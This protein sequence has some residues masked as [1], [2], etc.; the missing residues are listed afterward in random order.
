M[1]KND[2]DM[3]S[4]SNFSRQRV[5]HDYLRWVQRQCR[6]FHTLWHLK[7]R[8]RRLKSRRYR[9]RVRRCETVSRS[10][11]IEATLGCVI[12]KQKGLIEAPLRWSYC[13]QIPQKPLSGGYRERRCWKRWH[14]ILFELRLF[15]L[16]S[17]WNC[18][19]R[20]LFPSQSTNWEG[21][22]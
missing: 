8:N 19:G 5:T 12:H 10:I 16:S 15:W 20:V 1:K 6:L 14:P 2:V 18:I 9:S 4:F 3:F 22:G 17:A 11:S 13:R 21:R 7:R